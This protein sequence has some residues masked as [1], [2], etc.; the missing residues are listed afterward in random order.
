MFSPTT[1]SG[2]VENSIV[3]TTRTIAPGPR[4]APNEELKYRA[5]RIITSTLQD[6]IML[7]VVHLIDPLVIWGRLK[8][9]YEVENMSRKLTLKEQLYT[10][11][12]AEG[13]ILAQHLQDKNLLVKQLARMGVVTSYEDLVGKVLNSLPKNWST[14]RHIQ[15]RCDRPLLFPE[16]EGL[17]LYEEVTRNIENEQEDSEA[18]VYICGSVHGRSR[19]HWDSG[20][21]HGVSRVIRGRGY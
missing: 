16:L 6:S 15:W 19:F 3:P 11:K 21:G 20:Q 5:W 1:R 18:A 13:I 9:M 4:T 14:F 8:V 7:S 12:L 17:L 10:L 2:T